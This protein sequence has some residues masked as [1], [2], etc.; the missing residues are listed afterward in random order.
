MRGLTF[1]AVI[2]P[3]LFA[4]NPLADSAQRKLDLISDQNAKRGS[5]VT[6]TPQ[7]IN[8][9]IGEKAHKAFPQGVRNER[10]QLGTGT[11]DGEAL[12]DLLKIAQAKGREVNGLIGRLIEGERLLKISLRLESAGGRATVFL[13]NVELSG[14][15]ISGGALDLLMKTFVLPFYPDA[16]VNQPFD[17][18]Y[19]IERID[20][21]PTGVRV[22]IRK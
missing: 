13:T 1:L 16:K 2:V 3:A 21:Q 22:S 7:E 20:V 19:N 9:W 17:L 11:A 6:L 10:I 5:V 12:V 4:A 18:D 14:V 15:S 8:A